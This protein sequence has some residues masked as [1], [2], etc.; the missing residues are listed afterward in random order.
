MSC[1]HENGQIVSQIFIDS[2][3][4][5]Y[6]EPAFA[7]TNDSTMQF[8]RSRIDPKL[9][10]IVNESKYAGTLAL[11][12]H[13]FGDIH[14]I[15]TADSLIRR[16]D[17]NFNHR[18]AQAE[19]TMVSYSI[20]QHRFNEADTWLERAKQN[21]L[22]KYDQLTS[23]FDVDFELGRN[24]KAA[25]ELKELKSS[26]DYGYFFRL[27]KMDHLNGLLDSSIHAMI[28]AA[29]QESN[30]PYL[31]QVAL[32]NA[33]DLYVHAGALKV[34][35][36]LYEKCLSINCTDFHSLMGLGW[37]ALAHDKNDSLS[38]RIFEFVKGKNKLPDPLFK[39]T[40]MAQM[41]GDS[42]QEKKWALAFE[43]EAT[44]NVYGNMYNKYMIE[45]YT[46][47]LHN[48]SKAEE[49]SMRELENRATAQTYAWYA[50]SLF[51]NNKKK[52]AYEVFEK[53]VSGRPLEGLELYW[54]GKMMQGMNKEYNARSFFKAA[55]INKYDLNPAIREYLEKQLG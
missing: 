17:S 18:E 20:L 13:L 9:P 26:G 54:M 53:N 3:I 43:S 5:H 41:T 31:Y 40:Q 25:N 34:A 8:W 35:A 36:D 11:R 44:E 23:S 10:G 29:N 46:G 39:L 50:W 38:E 1:S 33:A 7:R 30:S 24:F 4:S 28:Q 48:P 55:L 32:S 15:K 42:M 21:G 49:I 6:Q 45:L 12:F 51:S 22:K 47:I 2:L 27:S 52:E 16:L 37:I 19:L 14:D